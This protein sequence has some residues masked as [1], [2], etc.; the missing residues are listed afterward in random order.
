MASIGLASTGKTNG[1]RQNSFFILFEGNTH[2]YRQIF[3]DVPQH[4]DDL[5]P[6][7]YGHSIGRWEGDTLVVD[8]VGYNDKFW[9]DGAGHPHTTQL[10][11]IERF[12]RT[13]LNTLSWDITIIDPG[14]YQKPF[15]VK[16]T[17]TLA[18]TELMDYICQENNTNVPHLQGPASVQ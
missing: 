6:T 17:A 4:P 9:F 8:T 16:T 1:I 3:M 15:T 5:D 10:H 12:R 18:K 14:A 13:D 7:W 2:S 11:T